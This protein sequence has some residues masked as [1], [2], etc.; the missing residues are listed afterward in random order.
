MPLVGLRV[1]MNC[2]GWTIPNGTFGFLLVDDKDVEYPFA[3][4]TNQARPRSPL[5]RPPHISCPRTPP[6]APSIAGHCSPSPAPNQMRNQWV[7]AITTV[8]AAAEAT[9]AAPVFVPFQTERTVE[10][11]EPPAVSPPCTPSSHGD[12]NSD[13][14]TGRRASRCGGSWTGTGRAGRWCAWAT[15]ARWT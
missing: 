13:G 8:M 7:S 3:A 12:L 15:G 14:P 10:K 5:L 4:E 2:D 6:R 1:Q 11:R 9:V